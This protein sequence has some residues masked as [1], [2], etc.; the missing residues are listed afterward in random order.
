[1]KAKLAILMF[2]AAILCMGTLSHAQDSCD[3]ECAQASVVGHDVQT[4]LQQANLTGLNGL[5]LKKA[6]LTLETGSTLTDGVSVNFLIFTVKHQT[7]KGDTITQAITWQNVPKP[8]GESASVESLKNVLAKAVAT[9]AALA[10]NVKAL[11]LSEATITIKFVVDKDSSGSLSYKIFGI[12]LG[13]SV[14]LDKVSTN[15]LAVTLGG[16]K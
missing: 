13:P 5:V 4:A 2:N 12:N 16:P 6:V 14:D 15:T 8:A 1:M 3:Q 7:K 11:P 9:A 10:N